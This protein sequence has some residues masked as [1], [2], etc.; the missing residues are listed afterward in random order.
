[1]P[2]PKDPDERAKRLAKLIVSDI[3]VYNQDKIDE[4]IKQDTV[5]DLLKEDIEVGR[6][7]Y[8]KNI[9]PAVA[10]RTNYFDH[11]LVDILIKGRGNVPS[12]IW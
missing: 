10:E 2:D 4:G 1:M 12:K 6:T 11:A 9:D 7:Y 8:E 5:F 3:I